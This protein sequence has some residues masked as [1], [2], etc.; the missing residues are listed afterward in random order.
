ML[1][2]GASGGR[3]AMAGR[4]RQLACDERTAVNGGNVR[5]QGGSEAVAAA[6]TP[7]VESSDGWLPPAVSPACWLINVLAD[8]D[9]DLQPF[10]IST[11]GN[12]QFTPFLTVNQSV[13]Q[14]FIISCHT[15]TNTSIMPY[16]RKVLQD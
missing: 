6:V 2:V 16:V 15:A 3:M 1:A 13:N 10:T 9:A 8:R 5:Y 7:P 4:L 14:F 12:V 11:N